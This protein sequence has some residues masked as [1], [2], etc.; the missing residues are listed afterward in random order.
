M[1]S[2]KREISIVKEVNEMQI[3]QRGPNDKDGELLNFLAYLIR[4]ETV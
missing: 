1:L 3:M 2:L 4:N